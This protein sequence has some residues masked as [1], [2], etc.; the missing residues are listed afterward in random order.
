[1]DDPLSGWAELG[2]N[3]LIQQSAAIAV[4]WFRIPDAE[5]SRLCNILGIRARQLRI[6]IL[7]TNGAS[8]RLLVTQFTIVIKTIWVLT[9][10]NQGLRPTR[11]S[12]GVQYNRSEETE[13]SPIK[14]LSVLMIW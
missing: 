5:L 12:N 1:M 4:L 10:L 8:W 13:S 6:T 14:Q 9:G 11:S 2:M 7:L 3:K